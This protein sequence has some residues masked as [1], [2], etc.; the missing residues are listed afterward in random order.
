MM[1]DEKLLK[2]PEVDVN[3][4]TNLFENSLN[5]IRIYSVLT[6]A[7]EL[8]LFD[9][10]KVPKSVDELASELGCDK[11]LLLLLCKILCKLKLLSEVDGKFVNTKLSME[12][13]TSDSFYSQRVFIEN[14]KGILNLWMNLTSILKKG[15]IK[16]NPDKFFAE[17][18]IHSLAQHSLLGEL[19]KIVKIISNLPE[20]WNA[21]KLLDLGGGHGLYAIAFTKL[22]PK[23]EAYVFDLPNVIEKTKEYIRKFKGER[24]KVLAG[25]FFTDNIGKNYDI[26]FSSYNPG[27][28]NPNLISKIYSSLNKGGIYVN[29]QVFRDNKEISLLDL[30]WNLWRFEGIEKGIKVYTF[31]NDLS[32][33]EYLKSLEEVGFKILNIIHLDEDMGT[34]MIVAK[35][36]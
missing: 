31:K 2:V 10:L 19:Q 28:K 30:E 22:N 3:Y 14:T 15:A 20:F 32:F 27:G 4:F 12:L 24:V 8:G 18:A 1:R 11:K 13:L 33:K 17:R 5:G 35:K 25:N 21:R 36:I 34:K 16:R 23:L 26:V 7:L 6:S 9:S 29:K